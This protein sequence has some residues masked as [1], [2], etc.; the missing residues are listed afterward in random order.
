MPTP[1]LTALPRALRGASTPDTERTVLV[2]RGAAG[3][4][5]EDIQR[6]MRGEPSPHPV[7]VTRF[8]PRPG[9]EA[10]PHL[11]VVS[12]PPPEAK[13]RRKPRASR[14]APVQRAVPVDAPPVKVARVLEVAPFR[15]A[16]DDLRLCFDGWTH[17][18]SAHHVELLHPTTRV[19]L[20]RYVKCVHCGRDV[21]REDFETDEEYQ[22]RDALPVV[23][24]VTPDGERQPQ[25][26]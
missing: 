20:M 8:F 13:K 10:P 15:V 25:D 16:A 12:T 5:W 4:T 2:S 24:W 26:E 3:L 22:A 18:P 17:T 7:D 9:R 21:R 19:L 1:V 23:E 14:K 6:D 11:Q